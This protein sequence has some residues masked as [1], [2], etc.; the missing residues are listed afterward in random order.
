[1]MRKKRAERQREAEKRSND[2][3]DDTA[4]TGSA[5]DSST[6][7][8]TDSPNPRRHGP[9]RPLILPAARHLVLSDDMQNITNRVL[10]QEKE[11]EREAFDHAGEYKENHYKPKGIELILSFYSFV[12]SFLFFFSSCF[13]FIVNNI[14]RMFVFSSEAARCG[15]TGHGGVGRMGL[16]LYYSNKSN[17]TQLII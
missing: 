5:T 13:W 17:G 7:S 14:Y 12:L 11:E 16:L 4:S 6:A 10:D 1:M 3:T 8:V 9:S 15:C 2:S